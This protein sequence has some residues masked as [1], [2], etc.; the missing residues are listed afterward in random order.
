MK[1]NHEKGFMIPAYTGGLGSINRRTG[2][3][4]NPAA[5]EAWRAPRE[6]LVFSAPHGRLKEVIDGGSHSSRVGRTT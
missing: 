4:K 2:E 3:A 6:P 5:A 1:Q